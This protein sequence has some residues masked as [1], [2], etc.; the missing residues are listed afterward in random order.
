MGNAL[1]IVIGVVVVG[2]VVFFG[3]LISV[4]NE[5]LRKASLELNSL[6]N[7]YFTQRIRLAR[8]QVQMNLN[9]PDP[10]AW[11]S[12]AFAKVYGEEK[13][14][15]KG[16]YYK[17]P[18]CYK[19]LDVNGRAVLFTTLPPENLARM[20]KKQKSGKLTL[21][22]DNPLAQDRQERGCERA[23][24]AQHILLVR[25]RASGRMEVAHWTTY[26]G[27]KVVGLLQLLNQYQYADQKAHPVF[28]DELFGYN[29]VPLVIGYS[30][31]KSES[32]IA[33]SD[34]SSKAQ[35]SII[36]FSSSVRLC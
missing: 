33:L 13:S 28:R 10:A 1:D 17:D 18:E 3:A 7:G 25:P 21:G 35:C 19:M 2:A 8:G 24:Y 6:A 30:S 22:Q 34:L 29:L 15:V 20:V 4:G 31:V 11:L 26:N 9:I 5:R 14:L 27:R 36:C 23:Q 32:G 16:Q 12:G